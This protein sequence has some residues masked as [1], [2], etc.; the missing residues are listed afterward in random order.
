MTLGLS[1]AHSVFILV[2]CQHCP[3]TIQ[4]PLAWLIVNDKTACP[5]C[6]KP[7]DLKGGSY[8]PLIQKLAKACAGIDAAT[9]EPTEH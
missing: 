5:S 8:G 6:R 1:T 4:K 2:Q 7:I 3:Q 9:T